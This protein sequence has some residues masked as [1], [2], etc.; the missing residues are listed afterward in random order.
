M[1]LY[2]YIKSR[3]ITNKQLVRSNLFGSNPQQQSVLAGTSAQWPRKAFLLVSSSYSIDLSRFHKF[4]SESVY[5]QESFNQ[6][7]VYFA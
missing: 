5:V 1:M 7:L 3:Q 4:L 6:G 2:I